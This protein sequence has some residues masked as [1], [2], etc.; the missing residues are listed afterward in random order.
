MERKEENRL[1]VAAMPEKE[2]K[3]PELGFQIQ[4]PEAMTVDKSLMPAFVRISSS[5]MD[6]K[7]SVESSPY[8]DIDGYF[9]TYLYKY[10]LDPG[11]R[12]AND[13]SLTINEYR[14]INGI[15]TRIM[16]FS[17][18]S[19]AY[20]HGLFITGE[21][22]FYSCFIRCSLLDR[23]EEAVQR[24][25]ESFRKIEQSGEPEFDIELSPELPDWNSETRAFYD[26]LTGSDTIKWG[27]FYP[28][29]IT[30][31]FSRIEAMEKELDYKFPITLHYIYL[32]HEFP[33]SGMINAHERG[34]TVELTMQV[35]WN[36]TPGNRDDEFKNVNFDVPDGLYD[37]Y[38]RE[39][40][41]AAKVFGHPF[42]FRLNNEMN[43]TWVRYGG[44]AL[45]CD[46]DIYIKVWR[47]IY[48]IFEEEGVRNA[49]WV[50]N[51]NDAD[52]PPLKWNS[53]ISYYPGDKYV[54][55]IGLTGY[56]TG[57]YYKSKT[58]ENWRS[59]TEIYGPLNEKYSR[60]Y[61]KFP[62]MI[63][64]FACS[65]VGGDKE[66]WIRDMFSNI[67]KY[68]NIKAAVWWSYADFDYGLS[69]EGIP[70]RRYWLD[71]KPEYLKAFK[72]GLEN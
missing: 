67:E 23:Q 45:L 24:I 61:S 33:M 69:K 50:F 71:E 65:S 44:I 30:R 28:N 49:I 46:P 37:G 51:P 2:I 66:K 42:I 32:G 55:M 64:E 48:D 3:C 41:K 15:R 31:D 21:K 56:N 52:Y 26:E 14:Y 54:H 36:V 18:K 5:G 11:Y 20:T 60:L 70:A 6:I 58:E 4:V 39:F 62:W 53:H 63:T 7:I 29:S 12:E 16:A 22:E 57:T 38:L 47:H 8:A 9:N 40:A 43:S 19:E 1:S 59:F 13:I 25:L 10:M 68:K 34:K 35:M 27:I 72:E 17:R